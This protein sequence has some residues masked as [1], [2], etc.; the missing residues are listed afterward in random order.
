MSAFFFGGI[1]LQSIYILRNKLSFSDYR[2]YNS[3]ESC[4]FK[5]N[6]TQQYSKE[7]GTITNEDISLD[8]FDTNKNQMHK[9]IK[10]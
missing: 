1:M 7:D 4:S 3:M 2:D 6:I 10:N 9:N 5:N 8:A